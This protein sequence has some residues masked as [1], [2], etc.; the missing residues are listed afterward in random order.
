MSLLMV[1][2]LAVMSAN[3]LTK[4]GCFLSGPNKWFL[5]VATKMLEQFHTDSECHFYVTLI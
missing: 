4:T 2:F 1:S 5:S 3:I